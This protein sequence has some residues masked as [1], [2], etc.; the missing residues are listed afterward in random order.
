MHERVC[1]C[2]PEFL[3]GQ[4]QVL[5]QVVALAVQRVLPHLLLLQLHL[6]QVS[7]LLVLL[8]HLR[9]SRGAHGVANIANFCEQEEQEEQ[10]EQVVA[11]DGLPCL[12]S[13]AHRYTLE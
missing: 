7:Q 9:S 8:R 6:A 10:E 12:Q 13:V 11:V 4:L 2:V 5:Q 1:V 3:F